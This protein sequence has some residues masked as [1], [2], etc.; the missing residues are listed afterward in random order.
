MLIIAAIATVSKSY[1]GEWHWWDYGII[2]AFFIFRGVV[3]WVIHSWIYHANPLPLFGIRLF[4][5]A[6]RQHVEHHDNP[7]DLARLL[8]TYKG[9]V[10]LSVFTFTVSSLVLQSINLAFTMVLG[11]VVVGVMIE[12]IHLVCHSDIPHT[13]R[14]MKRV[15]WLHRHHHHCDGKNF[16]GVSSSLGDRLFGTFPINRSD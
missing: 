15:V 5:E 8:I 9:I 13:S 4:G 12:I 6:Y 11:L 16:Y 1:W 7:N 10:I 2:C 3:E 14:I